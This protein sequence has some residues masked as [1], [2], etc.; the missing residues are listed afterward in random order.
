ML[1]NVNLFLDGL[2]PPAAAAAAAAGTVLGGIDLRSY[3]PTDLCVELATAIGTWNNVAA[4]VR[5][6]FL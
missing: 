1:V 3:M 2:V 6:E 5:I 4:R